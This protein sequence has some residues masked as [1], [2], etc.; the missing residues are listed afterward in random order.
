MLGILHPISPQVST[1]AKTTAVSLLVAS[2]AAGCAGT[3]TQQLQQ[4]LERH[5]VN[6]VDGEPSATCTYLGE[7]LSYKPNMKRMLDPF[8]SKATLA[9]E[10]QTQLHKMAIKKGAN[11]IGVV[12]EN[13]A[14]PIVTVQTNVFYRC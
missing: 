3:S 2:L 9:K 7:T 5:P 11:I 12:H 14:D 10:Q 8:N 4:E 13:Y 1:W 6:F